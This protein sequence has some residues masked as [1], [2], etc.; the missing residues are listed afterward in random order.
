[1]KNA[2]SSTPPGVILCDEFDTFFTEVVS[3]SE[4]TSPDELKAVFNQWYD[5][6]LADSL[7]QRPFPFLV[8]TTNHKEKIE[9]S[10]ISRAGQN[11]ILEFKAMKYDD[12]ISLLSLKASVWNGRISPECAWKDLEYPEETFIDGRMLE[13]ACRGV[14]KDQDPITIVQLAIFKTKANEDK[15]I[16]SDDFSLHETD[17]RKN[18]PLCTVLARSDILY[19][20]NLKVYQLLNENSSANDEQFT[21]KTE[22]K[23]LYHKK[24][25]PNKLFGGL[26]A[27]KL[28]KDPKNLNVYSFYVLVDNPQQQ[29]QTS[30]LIQ[31]KTNQLPSIP[32]SSKFY[33]KTVDTVLQTMLPNQLRLLLLRSAT[34][35]LYQEINTPKGEFLLR[36]GDSL[37]E[38]KEAQVLLGPDTHTSKSTIFRR[39]NTVNPIEIHKDKQFL[40]TVEGQLHLGMDGAKICQEGNLETFPD[41]VVE[42]FESYISEVAKESVNVTQFKLLRSLTS[43]IWKLE[44]RESTKNS[45]FRFGDWLL[46]G[47]YF[48][49]YRGVIGGVMGIYSE[50]NDSEEIKDGDSIIYF[51]NSNSNPNPQPSLSMYTSCNLERSFTL[52]LFFGLRDEAV[53]TNVWRTCSSGQATAIIMHEKIF[54]NVGDYVGLFKNITWYLKKP[55]SQEDLPINT[56]LYW[57]SSQ[58]SYIS[59]QVSRSSLSGYTCLE[60]SLQI[61]DILKRCNWDVGCA[62]MVPLRNHHR[63]EGIAEDSIL[64]MKVGDTLR[65]GDWIKNNW[66]LYDSKGYE[67]YI[68]ATN[69]H[70]FINQNEVVYLDKS[71]KIQSYLLKN[72]QK[73]YLYAADFAPFSDY[74]RRVFS[75]RPGNAVSQGYWQFHRQANSENYRIFN[76][77]QKEYLTVEGSTYDAD[78]RH[79]F[80]ARCTPESNHKFLFHVK[81]FS[82]G[83]VAFRNI[84]FD[85]YIYT[86]DYG[87]YDNDRRS[88]FTWVPKGEVRQC[89]FRLEKKIFGSVGRI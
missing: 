5:D 9:E 15:L 16:N 37:Y 8:A 65:T 1:M 12:V 18:L 46:S 34:D 32:I 28:F 45:I 21:L 24:D 75:W 78:R 55:T 76:V 68:N 26:K 52:E 85:E 49:Q 4:N 82:D 7:K 43:N 88:T 19:D 73:E 33:C 2:A 71:T 84:A 67:I 20:K 30:L 80:T 58:N 41:L 13:D 51:A 54:E 17:T 22:N 81:K 62:V 44:T 61:L 36:I 77:R 79:V 3:G 74:Y 23:F 63:V 47:R 57:K 60:G 14:E 39:C 53:P 38:N 10:I 31:G 50:L 56:T 25:E 87:A 11:N 48:T 6:S 35:D 72:V 86:A 29:I 69:Y 27:L 59:N 64:Y 66:K 89:Y 83:S 70:D 40:V 42:R